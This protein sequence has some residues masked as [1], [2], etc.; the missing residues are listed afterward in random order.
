MCRACIPGGD[1]PEELPKETGKDHGLPEA[2]HNN[3]ARPVVGGIEGAVQSVTEEHRKLH[4]L[5]AGDGLLHI[6]GDL[7]PCG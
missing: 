2:E 3:D 1:A 6:L 4:Q 5:H 7:H